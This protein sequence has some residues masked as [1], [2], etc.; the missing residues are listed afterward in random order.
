MCRGSW[1]LEVSFSWHFYLWLLL[2]MDIAISGV[3]ILLFG[4]LGA[5][6]LAPWGPFW[7]LGDTLGEQ[8]EGHLGV[9]NQMTQS[10]P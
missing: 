8:Q 6:P 10:T 2:Y 1:L 5:C 9:Q 4:R 3:Q 7:Q